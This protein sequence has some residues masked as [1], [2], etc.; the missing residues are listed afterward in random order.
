MEQEDSAEEPAISRRKREHVE[1]AVSLPDTDGAGWGDIRLVHHA[2]PDVDL[3]DVD[4]AAPF[5]G[6]TL[7]MPLVI[8]GMTGAHAAATE[9]NAS[10]AR[11]AQREGL[12]IGVGSQRAALLHPELARSF[13]V[14]RTEAPDALVIAN[15]GVSQLV[16]QEERGAFGADEIAAVVNMVQADALAVHLNFLEEVVQPEGQT[17]ALGAIGAIGRLVQTCPVPVIAKETGAGISR[18]VAELLA[19]A[20]VAAI[21]VGGFGGTSFLHIESARAQAWGDGR[22]VSL[23]EAFQD[24]GIPT[25]VSVAACAPV[26]PTLA[27]GGVRTGAD[28]AKA[29]A[30]GAVAVGVGRPL[31]E[32]ALEGDDAVADWIATFRAQLLVA[33]FLSGARSVGDL[34]QVPRV[35]VGQTLQWLDQLGLR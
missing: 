32:R 29:L 16:E 1:V 21:D 27:V 14:V 30:L 34:R 22:R 25:A 8:P 35:V 4:L 24:W 23:G 13:S 33:T 10:L 12:A 5:L 31:I 3:S 7:S 2:L 26:L 11:A 20:G 28:A 9:V 6:S 19:G 15:I 18:T 17:R